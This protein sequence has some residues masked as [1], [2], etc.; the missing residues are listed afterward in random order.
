MDN[1][2]HMKSWSID[3][4]QIHVYRPPIPLI[5]SNNDIKSENYCVKIK[6]CRDPTFE[7]QDIYEFKMAL[8]DNGEFDEFLLFMQNSNMML[9]E[10]WMLTDNK[11][12]QYIRTIIRGQALHQ[13]D[14]LCGQ[15]GSTTMSH[16]NHLV[17]GL[18]T[19]FPPMN[20]LYKNNRVVH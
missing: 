14:T 1:I 8:F 12:L 2:S 20:T 4:V 9:N 3:V 15:V 16:L 10:S 17:L 18:G 5:K 6:F 19:Y 7:N 13:L 11:K